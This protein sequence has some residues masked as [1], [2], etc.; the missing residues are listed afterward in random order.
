MSVIDLYEQ[1]AKRHGHYCPMST[2]GLRLGLEMVRRLSA[3]E[4]GTWQLCYQMRTCA[5]D[6]IAMA[7]E[8]SL[9]TAELQVDPQG[10]HLLLCAADDGRELSLGLS[11]EALLLAGRYRALSDEEKPQ[12]LELLRHIAVERIID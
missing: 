6:G 12:H 8:N 2:L 5:A 11:A 9:L 1:L 3:A 7:L 10:Q 4:H